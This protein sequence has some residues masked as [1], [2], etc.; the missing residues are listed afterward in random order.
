MPTVG[1]LCSGIG[2]LDRGL[3]RAGWTDLRWA[4]ERVPHRREVLRRHWGADLRVFE[5]LEQLDPA[6][7]EPVDLLAAGTP[8]PDFSHAKAVRA[9]LGGDQSR[10]FWD[11]I[12]IRDALEPDWTIWENVDGALRTKVWTSHS[13][14]APSWAPASMFPEADGHARVWSPAHGEALSGAFSTLNTSARPNDAIASSLSD[15]LVAHAP[16]RF[17]LSPRAAAGILR[18]ATRRRKTLPALLASA[19]RALSGPTPE[20]EEPPAPKSSTDTAPTSQPER[21]W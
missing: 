1:S 14:W 6:D 18:R 7:L 10:L 20:A 11:F 12:R 15:A 17:C 19:L 16:L 8:C 5:D 2:G 4:C 13:S 21:L 9:G 3:H